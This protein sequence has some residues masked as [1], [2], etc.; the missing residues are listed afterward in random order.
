MRAGRFLTAFALA[1][2]FGATVIAASP[3]FAG[4]GN[5]P[6]TSAAANLGLEGAFGPLISPPQLAQVPIFGG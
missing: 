1:A 4:W 6:S 3:A 2:T 5:I